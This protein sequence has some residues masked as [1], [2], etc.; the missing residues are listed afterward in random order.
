[1]KNNDDYS[2]FVAIAYWILAVLFFLYAHFVLKLSD[3]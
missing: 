1:M 2:R 3:I